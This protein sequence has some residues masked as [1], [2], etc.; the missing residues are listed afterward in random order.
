MTAQ[1]V[2]PQSVFVVVP[3]FN[4]GSAVGGVVRRLRT[5]GYTVVVVDD[6]SSDSTGEQARS[7]GA[8]VLRH[9]MNIGQGGALQTGIAFSVRS[10]ARLICTFDA[11]GQHAEDD[12]ARVA[13]ALIEKD[14]DVVLGSR[15]LG[16][17]HGISRSRRVLLKAA[18]LFTR[19]HSGLKLTDAHNGLR[20][21]RA[22]AAA[23]LAL[24]QMG[25]AHASEIIDQIALHKFKYC[26]A[27]VTVNY[28]GYSKHKG[29]NSLG[30]IRIVADL[31]IGRFVK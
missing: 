7:A 8:I 6:G 12:I 9:S 15:F 18:V 1:V 4:E 19:L 27:P 26:E 5:R 29:Q 13:A 30:S 31:V 2:Q 23:R 16:E 24:R 17:A 21:F 20:M 14:V 11:D 22:D 3:A 10:G 28:T 25:M